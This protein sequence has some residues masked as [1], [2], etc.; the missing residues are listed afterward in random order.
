MIRF[1]K[2][3]F[4]ILVTLAFAAFAVANHGDISLD[5][6]PLPYT[7]ELP[8]FLLILLC[9]MLGAATAGL[10]T[11]GGQFRTWNDLRQAKKRIAA[12]ENELG[13]LKAERQ[14][15]LSIIHD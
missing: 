2:L 14:S 1:I 7:A 6:S 3:F 10:F 4:L 9:I 13:G 5:F 8:T 15:P 11:M 12:L